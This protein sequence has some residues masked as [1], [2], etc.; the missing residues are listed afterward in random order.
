MARPMPRLPPVTSTD[1]VMRRDASGYWGV[2]GIPGVRSVV[3]EAEAELEADLEVLDGV[4]LDLAADL[5]DL[6]PVEVAQRLRRP[7]DAV[8]DGLVD[9]LGGRPDDL[10]D[11]VDTVGHDDA[12]RVA[13]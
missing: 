1:L 9:A 7:L 8:A 6:E 11:A 12:P 4:V 2:G 13:A 10:G 3:L 5:G